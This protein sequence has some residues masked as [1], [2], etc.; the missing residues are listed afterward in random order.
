[1]MNTFCSGMHKTTSSAARICLCSIFEG[2]RVFNK[3]RSSNCIEYQFSEGTESILEIICQSAQRS[4]NFMSWL[5][6]SKNI[7]I[8]RFYVLKCHLHASF[9]ITLFNS[10]S[11]TLL[12]TGNGRV[13]DDRIDTHR[14]TLC[15]GQWCLC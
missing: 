3:L 7:P 14:R 4:T 9:H 6:N 11:R 5:V 13:L 12:Q 10:A 1:M 2:L 15:F 8:A